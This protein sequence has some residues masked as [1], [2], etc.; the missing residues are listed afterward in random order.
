MYNLIS[1]LS[2]LEDLDFEPITTNHYVDAGGIHE[3]LVITLSMQQLA[4]VLNHVTSPLQVELNLA[5]KIHWMLA[6][7][8]I[9][10]SSYN[11]E[12]NDCGVCLGCCKA[13]S[14]PMS[15]PTKEAIEE[16]IRLRVKFCAPN[17]RMSSFE[18]AGLIA[19]IR[20]QATND[21]HE[22][23]AVT[24]CETAKFFGAQTE[25]GRTLIAMAKALRA[26]KVP[27]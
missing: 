10:M 3:D 19:Y 15:E 7:D 9:Y 14:T 2:V 1:T 5:R 8:H 17:G 16:S 24:C 20:T 25:R 13:A 21:T 6:N 4:E 27:T 23:N 11:D 22:A 12:I 26:M 18:V